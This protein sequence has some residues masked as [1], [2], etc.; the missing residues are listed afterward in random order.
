MKAQR[1]RRHNHQRHP[2][3]RLVEQHAVRP[4]AVLAEPLAMIPRDDDERAIEIGV[5]TQRFEHHVEL[6]V[7]VRDLA[8]V[9]RSRPRRELR[10]RRV[11][12]VRIVKVDPHEE[13]IADCGLRIAD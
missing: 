1:P 4:L 8:V 2:Q 5:F 7:G 12:R 9:R 3:R 6:R 11:G 13:R 10:R